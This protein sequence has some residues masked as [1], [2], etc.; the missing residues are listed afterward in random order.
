M[1]LL[2]T[3]VWIWTVDAD[4]RRV[5]HATRRQLVRAT[6]DAG[7]RISPVSLFEVTALHVNGRIHFSRPL[8]RWLHDALEHVRLAELTAEIAVDAGHIPRTALPD[9][10]DRLL[11]ATARQLE[12]PLVTGDDAILAYARDGHVRVHDASR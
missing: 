11:V 8:E 7:L 5:G 10:M 6:A 4:E 1:L 9:P 2:D 12:C 3:H